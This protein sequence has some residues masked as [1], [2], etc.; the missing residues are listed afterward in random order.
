MARPTVDDELITPPVLNARDVAEVFRR[1]IRSDRGLE[2][3]P[4][5][6]QRD[7]FR[8][9]VSCMLS[10]QSPDAQTKLASDALFAR[11]TTPSAI[12]ALG[13]EEL[14]ALIKPAGLYN[15]K[16]KNIR[17]MC[18]HLL[19]HLDG[20][21]PA[22][23]EGMMALPGVGRKCAD[24]M[25]RFV[26]DQPVIAVDTH[27]HRVCNRLGLARGKTDAQTAR[28]LEART[29]QRYLHDGHMA[30][31]NHGKRV[32]RARNPNCA[33]CQLADLCLAVRAD[34]GPPPDMPVGR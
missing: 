12:L 30:L 25:L 29:P 22:T 7:T 32:C 28:H 11:A 18:R 16:A 1:L 21:V 10:A 14:K 13:D 9:L 20:E 8:S 17:A 5:K 24:I 6:V 2:V 27:V 4:I 19:E 33:T 23:R 31:I 15:M 26:Y 3:V 34:R